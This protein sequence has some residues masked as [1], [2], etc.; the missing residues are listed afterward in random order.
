MAGKDSCK[1]CEIINQHNRFPSDYYDQQWPFS[2]STR[3]ASVRPILKK[4]ERN[5]MKNCTVTTSNCFSKLHEKFLNEQ[6]PPF[7]SRNLIVS[8]LMRT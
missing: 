3:P 6:I 4:N 2:D 1:N 8:E 5:E 7:V